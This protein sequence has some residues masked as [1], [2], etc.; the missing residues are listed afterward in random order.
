MTVQAHLESLEKKH[1]ALEEELHSLM[2]SPSRK[3]T[4]IADC[5]RRKL[6]IKDE[7]QRLKS[8]VH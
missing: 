1:V 6:R 2:V 7:I 4:E 8:S 3:D 5:K